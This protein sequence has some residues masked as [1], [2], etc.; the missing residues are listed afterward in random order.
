MTIH[1]LPAKTVLV[2]TR[3]MDSGEQVCLVTTQR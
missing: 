1:H 2:V 3:Q